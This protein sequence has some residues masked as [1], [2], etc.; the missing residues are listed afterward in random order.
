LDK[1]TISAIDIARTVAS[2]IAT[3]AGEADRLGKL[4]DED[5]QILRTS[6]Y[7]TMS[8][9]AEYGGQGL[10]LRD[11]VAAHLELA[12]G[13]ASTALIAAMQLQ[14]FGFARETRLWPEPIFEKFCRAAIEDGAL[15][16]FLASEP[17]LG[18]P[19]HGGRYQTFAQ[20]TPRGDNWSVNGHKNWGTGGKHLTHLL[21]RLMVGD[22]IGVM[23]VPVNARGVEWID[24]WNNAL[25]VRASE[26]HDVHF[27]KVIVPSENLIERGVAKEPPNGWFTALVGATYLGAGLAARSAAIRYALDRVPTGL[28]KPIATLPRIQRQI[29]EI[30][31]ALQAAQCLLLDAAN[32]WSDESGDRQEQWVRIAAAKTFATETAARVSTIALQIAGGS[33]MLG[34]LPFERYFRDAQAGSTHPPSGDSAYEIVGQSAI[35]RW[36]SIH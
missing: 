3:R 33:G 24:T 25:S 34:D 9:P 12:Q 15:F 36:Q 21:V 28:G 26:S 10:S 27:K 18:S 30:D 20:P 4:P 31:V 35:Q 13:S 16:N 17:V 19:A 8:V 5:I 7:L 1:Q 14:V 11:C 29:G 2:D 32:A 23:Y 22:E 6:G